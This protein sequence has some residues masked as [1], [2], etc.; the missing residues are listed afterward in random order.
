MGVVQRGSAVQGISLWHRPIRSVGAETGLQRAPKEAGSCPVGRRRSAVE[1]RLGSRHDDRYGLVGRVERGLISVRRQRGSGGGSG[2]RVGAP[3]PLTPPGTAD[4]ETGVGRQPCPHILKRLL[5]GNRGPA[6][7]WRPT[8]SPHST[9]IARDEP[10]PSY[11]P[12][13]L[14]PTVLHDFVEPVADAL[15]RVPLPVPLLRIGL[16]PSVDGRLKRVKLRRPRRARREKSPSARSTS[17]R[18]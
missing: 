9:R 14:M 13:L 5:V 3:A 10:H 4:D 8:P 17:E 2:I 12:D 15:G 1:N 7:G 16:K 6:D 11:V 18:A